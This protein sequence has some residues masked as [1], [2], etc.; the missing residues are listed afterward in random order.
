[1]KKVFGY[2]FIVLSVLL[3]FAI[4]GQIPAVIKCVFGVF[5]LFSGRVDSEESG[6][7]CGTLF[8]WVL[9]FWAT[10]MLW[11]YGRK[12]IKKSQVSPVNPDLQSQEL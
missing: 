4:I 3:A 5:R 10:V 1:M 12:W 11:I 6:R 2:I 8:Y 9:H 7:I